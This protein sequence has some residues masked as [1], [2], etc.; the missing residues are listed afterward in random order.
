MSA[1][2]IFS[3]RQF[4]LP[5]LSNGEASVNDIVG[6]LLQGKPKTIHYRPI[7]A[8]SASTA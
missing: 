6:N 8:S 4:D 2:R 7:P 1:R 3:A 5:D